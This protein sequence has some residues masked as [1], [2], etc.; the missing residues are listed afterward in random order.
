MR[1]ACYPLRDGCYAL[2]DS[3]YELLNGSYLSPNTSYCFSDHSYERPN[4]NAQWRRDRRD[5]HELSRRFLKAEPAIGGACR[6]PLELVLGG[7][8]IEEDSLNEIH[9]SDCQR[10]RPDQQV[11]PKARNRYCGQRSAM[12]QAV[13]FEQS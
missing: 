13:S 4:G 12:R 7:G 2:R 3:S 1:G 5:S 6:R 11:N 8:K 9:R 10:N